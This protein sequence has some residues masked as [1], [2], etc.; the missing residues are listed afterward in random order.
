[1][2][3]FKNFLNESGTLSSS[4]IFT[5]D[6]K[7][8]ANIDVRFISE[9]VGKDVVDNPL[10]ATVTWRV[11]P[12]F[13]THRIKSMDLSIIGVVCNIEWD[14]DGGEENDI[15]CVDTSLPEFKD[16]TIESE[17][18]FDMWGGAMPTAVEID[19]KDKKIKVS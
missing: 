16:W 4:V 3:N 18:E 17:I 19:F 15:V 7:G 1:M 14:W 12:D 13:R 11:E 6:I 10:D 9:Y 2:K 8:I 5:T